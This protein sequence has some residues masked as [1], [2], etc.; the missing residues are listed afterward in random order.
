MKGKLVLLS[1]AAMLVL[2]GGVSLSKTLNQE[3]EER[4]ARIIVQLNNA[5]NEKAALKLQNVVANRI[6]SEVTTNFDIPQ[7]YT[8]AIN[9]FVMNVNAKHVTHIRNIIG[10]KDVNY[11]NVHCIQTSESDLAKRAIVPETVTKNISKETMNVPDD[12]NEGEGT[13]IA[14]L[15]TGFMINATYTD[16]KKTEH[17]NV[18]HV[19]FTALDESVEV[20]Y[21]EAGIKAAIDAAGND[22]HGK[23]DAD[24]STYFN[25]KVPFFYD[26]GGDLVQ[27]GDEVPDRRDATPDY[28]VFDPYN[29]H[30]NHVASIAAG[31]DPK[32][33]GIAPKAQLALMKV[34][35]PI[36]TKDSEGNPYASSGATDGAI[37]AAFDDCIALGVDV[38]NMSL[39]STLNDFSEDT[40]V[41]DAVKNLQNAGT[42]CA[43]AAGNDGKDLFRESAYEYWTTDMVE[44]GILGGYAG[45]DGTIVASIQPDEL[46]YESAL[47]V[48]SNIVAF[49]DQIYT[50]GTIEYEEE[51][52]FIDL[53]TLEGHEEGNFE[54]IKIPGWGEKDDFASLVKDGV[55][56]VEGKIAIIDRGEINFSVK[57]GNAQNNGAIAVG[58]IDNDPSATD[59]NFNMDLGGYQP[60]IPV[61]SILNRD[62]NVFDKATVFTCKLFKNIVESNPTARQTADSTSDGPVYD[63]SIK[64]EIATPGD[65]VFGAVYAEGPNSYE[66]YSGTSMATPNYAGVYALM[67]SEHLDDAAWKA[68]LSDRLMSSAKPVKDVYGT[69]VESI[70]RQGAG[71]VDVEAALNT[72]VLLDGSNDA[73]HL[74]GKTKIELKNN[75]QIKNGNV[76][77]TFTTI[78]NTA[79]SIEYTA[80]LS[81]YRP[82]L[83]TLSDKDAE[84]YGEKFE[85]VELMNTLLELITDEVE[86]TIT[87]APGANTAHISYELSAETKAF[88]NSKFPYGTYIEGYVTLT[89]EG[90]EDI[91][92]PY[93]GF[94]GDYSSGIPVEPFK[95]ERDESKLYPSDLVNSIGQKWKSL[96]GIDYGSDWVIGNFKTI[97]G[98]D[99][100]NY[101]YNKKLIRSIIDSNSKK[102]TPACTN[103]YTGEYEGTDIY[104]GNNGYSNTMIIQQFV[105][106]SVETN[107]LTITKKSNNEV[108][109]T[110]H[111]Y[112]SLYGAV[113]DENEKEIQWPLYKSFVDTAYWSNDL[114]AHRAYTL[115]PLYENSFDKEKEKYIVGDEFPEGEYEI[116]F[117]YE[118]ASGGHYEKKYTLHIDSS[119]PQVSDTEDIT[120]DGKEYLRIRYEELK[121]SY[122]VINGYRFPIEKDDKGYF[123]DI[124]KEKYQE[125]NKIYIKG[126]DFASASSNTLLK[127]NDANR[128]TVS[129]KSMT[130]AYSFEDG[131]T[132]INNNSFS[133]QFSF[134]KG[135]ADT[136]L[137]EDLTVTMK[138]NKLGVDVNSP[139]KV[140]GVDGSGNKTE[141][142]STFNKETG[143]LSFT[144]NS[145]LKFV[146]EYTAS[147]V[148]P[149]EPDE[150]SKK[151]GCGGS[152]IAG[153]AIL[154]ITAALGA[155]LL[156]FK[157]RKDD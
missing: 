98:I 35:T 125:V 46:Y 89:A 95:F 58:I 127:M 51:H 10:V 93:L 121:M 107:T 85:G 16:E 120:K 153:S 147:A 50:R 48:G 102:V 41:L 20:K 126:C 97:A 36:E 54:W 78:N 108:V 144:G 66:Y 42:L 119:V 45:S 29:D 140:Y 118:L 62:K 81:V 103:P 154:S 133:L 31:N 105:M 8:K 112:D 113:E 129:G 150:P 11:D 99:V 137:D 92:I 91:S 155:S 13:L 44:G 60:K 104:M 96:N 38:V 114:L 23:Y 123:I 65:G 71:L 87:V 33:H 34:F 156:L 111:M 27:K 26:Y 83:T 142:A 124:E 43:I 128:L 136:T 145:K 15:D 139:V 101:L 74:L 53:L 40:I 80:N 135:N 63:L 143:L 148:N 82:K 73:E 94:F 69:N 32:Y 28:D 79:D 39:G 55:N 3:K 21:S 134:K 109:L 64:P 152:L 57:I 30:G 115:I 149:D 88:L 52:Y 9:G 14:I 131:F 110:D 19:A 17:T 106:R 141:L 138:L 2:G 4:D 116:K 1:A 151:K 70:R 117:S 86:T 67:L 146:I 84:R 130:N 157:K 100:E 68:T 47:K 5:Q 25:S 122:V 90:E 24:H 59:F 61:V 12:T 77:L 132:K 6:R 76:D 75:D 56:P 37:L 49:Q 18:S 7:R 22:F 72:K